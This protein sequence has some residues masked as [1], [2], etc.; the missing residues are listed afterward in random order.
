MKIMNVFPD[1]VYATLF[2][3]VNKREYTALACCSQSLQQI[4]VF[5]QSELT[6]DS[7][8]TTT[9]H[10]GVHLTAYQTSVL[11]HLLL[12]GS[13]SWYTTIPDIFNLIVIALVYS[14][15]KGIT[16]E[17]HDSIIPHL[18]ELSIQLIELD[19]TISRKNN[20]KGKSLAVMGDIK[21]TCINDTR[22]YERVH[23]SFEQEQLYPVWVLISHLNKTPPCGNDDPINLYPGTSYSK[24][25]FVEKSTFYIAADT[26]SV[27]NFYSILSQIPSK[28]P[29]KL[30][31]SLRGNESSF[32]PLPLAHYRSFKGKLKSQQK[33]P[34]Y[35]F[36]DNMSYEKLMAIQNSVF[37]TKMAM[38]GTVERK[39]LLIDP[40]E[41]SDAII[42]TRYSL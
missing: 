22:G 23:P 16:V 12:Y 41:T 18:V 4:S 39:W 9:F 42:Q 11:R 40:T 3:V 13:E 2:S 33:L 10:K 32:I 21:L 35:I 15:V 6:L 25:D 20:L 34:G 27:N 8:S 29:K 38:K 37:T 19:L 28:T 24:Q 5:I 31:I 26:F 30:I 7:D 17:I 14:D 1:E 36:V